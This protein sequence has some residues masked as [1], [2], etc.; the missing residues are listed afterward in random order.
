[1]HDMYST[2][3][4][5]QYGIEYNGGHTVDTLQYDRLLVEQLNITFNDIF[6]NNI[7]R[8]KAGWVI[9]T[10]TGSISF[11]SSAL[12]IYIIARSGER[13]AYTAT[14]HRIVVGMCLSDMLSSF[15]IALTTIPMPKD[16]HQVYNFDG[17]AYGTTTT[18]EIQAFTYS[19]GA[20]LSFCASCFLSLYYLL[21]IRY[22]IS[23]RQMTRY[24]EPIGLI[25]SIAISC[26]PAVIL[27]QD[28]FLNPLPFITWCDFG[29]Y[30][31]GCFN[32]EGGTCIRGDRGPASQGSILSAAFVG[33]AFQILALSF[34]IVTVY[35]RE[36]ED[37]RV[38]CINKTCS[39]TD[40][41]VHVDADV[42]VEDP[43]IKDTE[44]PS[45]HEQIPNQKSSYSDTKIII[46][47]A[48]MYSAAFMITQLFVPSITSIS[49]N[50]TLQVLT[51]ILKPLQGFFNAIIFISHKVYTM[52]QTYDYMTVSEALVAIM[53]SPGKVPAVVVELP[54]ESKD[55]MRY[56][57]TLVE[58]RLR[59]AWDCDINSN[60]DSFLLDGTEQEE[61]DGAK[62]MEIGMGLNLTFSDN[63]GRKGGELAN[64]SSEASDSGCGNSHDSS[65]RYRIGVIPEEMSE[66]LST[67][68]SADK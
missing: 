46:K 29:D 22:S 45:Q 50:T 20:G 36:R 14:Y 18:C 24:V 2:T 42:G 34:V 61:A 65:Y 47:Q 43:V 38:T 12:I 58:S 3:T 33:A 9:P 26:S 21:T 8:T 35:N 27:I 6:E 23:N 1:M 52:R 63:Y 13:N 7:S 48:F 5:T 19:S 56:H 28:K 39:D 62:G 30:P 32:D 4:T 51:L 49:D 17:A 10:V 60:D 57:R 25:I 67:L 16:V 31:Y 66:D 54:P 37:A 68:P 11:V 44:N 59:V 55:V 53:M 15:A 64:S 41:N 40:V